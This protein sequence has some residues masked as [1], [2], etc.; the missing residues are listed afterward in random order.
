MEKFIKL[1]CSV[2]CLAMLLSS[3]PVAL[4]GT[5]DEFT[6]LT[7]VSELA[8]GD[9]IILVADDEDYA[10]S[11]RQ[12]TNHRGASAI[13]KYGDVVTA[14]ADTQVLTVVAG[15]VE[16]TFA[17]WTGDGYLCAASN[18]ANQLKTTDT[19]NADS[20]W[21]VTIVDGV[22]SLVAQGENGRNVLQ[23]NPNDGDPVF[24]CYD[25]P[26]M[27]GLSIYKLT[28]AAEGGQVGES[29][30]PAE[31]TI[32]QA[33]Q[34]AGEDNGVTYLVRGTVTSVESATFGNL[35]IADDA[36]NC[37]YICGVYDADGTNRYDA[38]ETKPSAGDE[39]VLLGRLTTYNGKPQMLN[40]W[41]Q[42]LTIGEPQPEPEPEKV[43]IRKAIAIGLAKSHNSFTSEQYIV[44]G[45]ITEIKSA[46][47]GNLYIRDAEGNS[48]YIYGLSNSDGTLRFDTMDPE[49]AVGDTI[50]V[51]GVL[52]RYHDTPQMKNGRITA[53][54]P[55]QSQEDPDKAADNDPDL[56]VDAPMR[57]ACAALLSGAV[58]AMACVKYGK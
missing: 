57:A 45:V 48:L 29:A 30:E 55:G 20:S 43:S 47:Y 28:K 37:L 23:Y 27:R 56:P 14:A 1:L 53:V 35:Y 12:K 46:T 19:L 33:L 50:T 5:G 34:I 16:G 51:V 38:M 39:V 24:S 8:V 52:G 49:P 21:L 25:S 2:L 4:A 40:G 7:D 42:S 36:G 44:T 15:I 3:L 10:L 54:V 18:T 41:L 26:K 31:V 22:T 58:G 13:T 9:Q 17:Y 11:T 32:A 6:K